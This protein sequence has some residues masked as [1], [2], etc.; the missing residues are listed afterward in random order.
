MSGKPSPRPIDPA[1][2]IGHV[3]LKVADIDRSLAFYCD[4]LGFELKQRY[5][6]GAAF[7]SAGGYHHHI[8]LNTWHSLGASPPPRNTTGL[9]HVAILY[10]TRAALADAVQRLMDAGIPL[11]G[12]SDHGVS[13]AIYLRDP[14]DIGIELYCDRP[15]EEWPR[16]PDGELDMI[17][18]P[19]DLADL[20]KEMQ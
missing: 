9:Y 14:D 15:R 19:L 6:P 18:K 2:T 5:G 20:M 8:G 4:V 11:S 12:S 13:E 7:I 17:I 1:V 3:H 16:T 10:P